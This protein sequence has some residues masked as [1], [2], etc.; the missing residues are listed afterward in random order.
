MQIKTDIRWQS[1]KWEL[2]ESVLLCMSLGATWYMK[3]YY[4]NHL[5]YKQYLQSKNI[6]KEILKD[7]IKQTKLSA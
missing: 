6:E 7:V 5:K 4:V 1:M 2:R 3:T